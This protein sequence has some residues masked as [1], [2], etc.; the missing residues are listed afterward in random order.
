MGVRMFAKFRWA[1]VI[2]AIIAL[3]AG[4]AA[5]VIPLITKIGEDDLHYFVVE[6]PV[7]TPTPTPTLA[8]TSSGGGLAPP[9]ATPEPSVLAAIDQE[10]ARLERACIAFNTPDRLQL[11]EA[12]IIQLLLSTE[13]SIPRLREQIEVPG[14]PEGAEIKVSAV[15]KASLSAPGFEVQPITEEI[16]P[17]SGLENTEWRWEIIP[18]KVGIQS[19]HLALSAVI[20]VADDPTPLTLRVDDG[21]FYKTLEV[22]TTWV[23]RVSSFIVNNWQWLW[24]AVLVPAAIFLSRRVRNLFS[25][26][27]FKRRQKP[28]FPKKSILRQ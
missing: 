11:G 28:I 6:E 19:L 3:F 2:A 27:V 4:I 8:D 21:Q 20:Y 15:M 13:Q 25:K 12:S 7:P 26:L 1:G 23:K 14:L 5:A 22:R 18:N 10:L 9:S 24:A 17:V 16:Q